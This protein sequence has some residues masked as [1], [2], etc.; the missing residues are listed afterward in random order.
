MTMPSPFESV[1][2]QQ[3]RL[4]QE[5]GDFDDLP[6]KGKPIPGRDQPDDEL[7]WVKGLI[8]RE[9]LSTE[10]LLPPSLQLRKEIERLPERVST[11]RTEA[12]VRAAVAELNA[13][14]VEWVRI[15]VGPRVALRP[16]DADEVVRGW[17]AARRARAAAQA[18]AD[19][20]DPAAA[21]RGR[22]RR[23][24]RRRP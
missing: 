2:E 22:R 5:R 13:R 24:W 20:V 15:P 18:P 19:P 12:A 21:E 17:Q 23:P 4:A 3:I 1:V 9:G 14:I 10:A 11:L 6:G 16:A 8:R 7:W